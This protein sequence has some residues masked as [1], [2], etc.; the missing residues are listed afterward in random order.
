M[1]NEILKEQVSAFMLLKMENGPTQRQQGNN[2]ISARALL[3]GVGTQNAALFYGGWNTTTATEEYN[4]TSYATGGALS[5]GGYAKI[6][7]GI[8]NAAFSTAGTISDHNGIRSESEQYDGASWS[9]SIPMLT[10]RFYG[11]AGSVNAGI[12]AYG[13]RNLTYQSLNCTELWNGTSWSETSEAVIS[14]QAAI[15]YG[16]QN[17][18]AVTAGSGPVPSSPGRRTTTQFFD[19]TAYSIDGDLNTL[20]MGA[21][22]RAPQ[23]AGLVF[24]GNNPALSSPQNIATTEE[25]NAY[26]TT[27]SFGRV[28][29]GDVHITN[30]SQLVVSSSLQLPVFTSNSGIVSSSAGQMWFNSTTKKLN[31]TVDVNTWSEGSALNQGG[32]LMGLTG[33]EFQAIAAG[34]LSGRSNETELWDGM[35]W[36]EVNDLIDANAHYL[37][38]IHISEPTRLLSIGGAG[39]CL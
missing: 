19:G 22:A 29:A 10:P 25:Y 21:G 9:N 16:T 36:T 33:D 39:V 38:L 35:S 17:A 24:G 37:S 2:L 13:F 4:G 5:Q 34:G 31:F 14:G 27:G 12:T 6:G 32:I 15:E 23:G 8:Q 28:E 18:F 3:T 26:Y 30:D 7:F 11:G 20:G 1:K